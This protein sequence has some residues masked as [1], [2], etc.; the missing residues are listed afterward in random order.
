[1]KTQYAVILV[2]G[3]GKRLKPFT[4]SA[5]KCMVEVHGISILENA[6][7]LFAQNGVTTSRIVVGHLSSV[8]R[9]YF[10][11]SFKN[12]NI[13]YIENNIYES[14]NS[15]YSLYL[16]L[17]G[18]HEPTW[19]LE[20]DVFFEY[21][22]L[23]NPVREDI[24]W[25]VD[26]KRKDLDGAYIMFDDQNRALSLEIIRDLKN[27]PNQCGKSIGL[28]H[29][30]PKGLDYF[31]KWLQQGVNVHQEKLYYDLVVGPHFCEA[32]IEIVDVGGQKWFEIDT[33]A[34]MENA[35]KLFSQE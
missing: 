17:Q 8:I 13:E 12:M 9:Q 22:V 35:Q 14:T 7:S 34:D 19:V 5:P 16:G 10:G 26:A 2:A 20:G 18:I 31:R 6:L 3:E 1:M 21:A 24:A 33:Y 4:D 29:L 28:L 15:M 25:F 30:N 27:L 23:T 11:L 32:K